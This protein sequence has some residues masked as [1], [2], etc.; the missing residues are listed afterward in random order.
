MGSL[1][2]SALNVFPVK[3]LRGHGVERTALDRRGP[4][5]DRRWMVVDDDGHFVTQRQIHRMALADVKLETQRLVLSA[6]GMPDLRVDLDEAQ[7]GMPMTVQVWSSRVLALN[8][9]S[10]AAQWLSDWL[11]QRLHLVFMPEATRRRV[12]PAYDRDGATVGF[13]DGFPLLLIGQA[14]LDDLN[15]RL[16]SPVPMIR[17]RP[18]LV[19][20]GA[21]AF[22]ED[23]WQELRIGDVRLHVAKPCGRC[24][25]PCIDPNSGKASAEP[26]RTLA[27]Y[28][29]RGRDVLF[30]QN[31]IHRNQ[32][33]ICVGDPVEVL[34]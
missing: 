17:F 27:A 33:E 2:V 19:V 32:G 14:S 30:G 31:L 26:L 25:I 8:A 13:A 29:R 3:S 5:W 15:A 12:H 28:R 6:P 1:R 16:D 22:A 23:D 11:G 34:A 18:N 10:D 9:G 20:S 4:V 7:Q 24:A 21:E